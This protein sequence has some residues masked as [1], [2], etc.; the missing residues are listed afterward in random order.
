M[1]L[2]NMHRDISFIQILHQTRRIDSPIRD[3]LKGFESKHTILFHKE[4]QFAL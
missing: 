2:I 3:R 4:M 1:C